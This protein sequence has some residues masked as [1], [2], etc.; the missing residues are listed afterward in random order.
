M[1]SAIALADALDED[2]PLAECLD[3]YEQAR[4][5]GVERLQGW[6]TRSQ[7][8]WDS[9]P[10]RLPLSPARIALAYLTRA[11]AVSLEEA[12]QTGDALVRTAVAEWADCSSSEVPTADLSQ[13]IVARPLASSGLH[14]PSRLRDHRLDGASGPARAT[15][16]VQ[17]GDAWGPDADALLRQAR[18]RVGEGDQVVVLSGPASRNALLDRCAVAERVRLE[19]QVPVAVTASRDDVADVAAALVSGRIDLACASPV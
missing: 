10:R 11:G 16:L 9:F 7:L 2:L 14:L 1:E 19:L 17:S 13:W 18:R 4:R 12:M 15:L 3:Q 8:W 5:P 6:A